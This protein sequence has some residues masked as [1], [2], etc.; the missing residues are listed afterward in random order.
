MRKELNIQHGNKYCV[1]YFEN[2]TKKLKNRGWDIYNCHS[3]FA[4]KKSHVGFFSL[5]QLLNSFSSVLNTGACLISL[6]QLSTLTCQQQV[7]AKETSACGRIRK[8][9]CQFL[10]D[11]LHKISFLVALKQKE[12]GEKKSTGACLTSLN[13]LSTHPCGQQVQV[14]ETSAC[15]RTIENCWVRFSRMSGMRYF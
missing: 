5:V 10:A 6:N 12:G 9:S 15:G 8:L 3:L 13:Q 14:Q 11:I 7:Q 4:N 2:G 1:K